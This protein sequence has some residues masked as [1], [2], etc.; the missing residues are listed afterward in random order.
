VDA[1]ELRRLTAACRKAG[2]KHFKN[3]EVEFT[4][5]ELPR[6]AKGS[7]QAADVS[8]PGEIESDAISPEALLF[9][10]SQGLDGPT[11]GD[12]Q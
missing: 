1:K 10:S 6:A 4:L 8:A 3:S 5:D 9:W 2:I 7:K 12:T 11:D